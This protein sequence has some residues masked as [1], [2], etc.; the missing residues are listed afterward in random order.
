MRDEFTQLVV[1]LVFCVSLYI[2]WY[3][4]SEGRMHDRLH[5]GASAVL[6]TGSDHYVARP[7]VTLHVITIWKD[8]RIVNL[9]ALDHSFITAMLDFTSLEFTG[10]RT[11]IICFLRV[12]EFSSG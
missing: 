2:P 5:V 9:S 6:S 1:Q 12:R 3:V 11:Q 7:I 4:T 10:D 8:V